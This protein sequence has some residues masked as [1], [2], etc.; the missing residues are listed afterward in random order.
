M[1]KKSYSYTR[2]SRMG[3]KK[4][5]FHIDS[6]DRFNYQ[7][8]T[9]GRYVVP[10]PNIVKNVVG[11]RLLSAE[12]PTSY[13][14][15]RQ[16]FGNTTMRVSLL[17]D[18]VV[19][20]NITIPDG[21]YTNSFIVAA[22]QT[23][24]ESTFETTFTCSIS[25]TTLK[26]SISENSGIPIKIHT[27]THDTMEEYSQTLSHF[28]GFTYKKPCEGVVVESPGIV[29]L[30]P[31]TYMIL[32]ITELHQG[33][34]EG[35]IYGTR[36]SPGGAFSKVPI[37]NNSFEYTFWEPKNPPELSYTP[38]L[39]RLDRLTVLWRFHTMHEV[40]F[41]SMDHSFTIE[42]T[43]LDEED[44]TK[45]DELVRM[46][47]TLISTNTTANHSDGDTTKRT[48]ERVHY[49]ETT[50]ENK[51]TPRSIMYTGGILLVCILGYYI[52]SRKTNG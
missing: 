32:D 41:N 49:I 48:K 15:F 17:G 33:V 3:Y 7:E 39:P 31:F 22:V 18:S 37:Y 42:I 24:L 4:H 26:M 27:D 46:F 13:Y 14:V 35:G 20:K 40:D 11:A 19:T 21:N 50:N 52:Y 2:R 25:V 1:K 47:R 30:N 5:I 29:S 43:T 12:L 45:E 51:G 23:A 28:L 44:Q 16:V 8:T 9:S 36:Y 10:T 38:S 6:R 34:Y